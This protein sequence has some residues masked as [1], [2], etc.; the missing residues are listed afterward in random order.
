MFKSPIE[1]AA[2]R[3]IMGACGGEVDYL[4]GRGEMGF[5]VNPEGKFSWKL[6]RRQYKMKQIVL[7]AKEMGMFLN[8]I[9]L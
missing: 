6:N 8:S 4:G 9:F 3:E 1:S 2:K 7:G 5:F